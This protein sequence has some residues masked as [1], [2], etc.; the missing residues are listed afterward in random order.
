MLLQKSLKFRGSELTILRVLL[1][2]LPFTKSK[3]QNAKNVKG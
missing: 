3:D 2:I 1:E